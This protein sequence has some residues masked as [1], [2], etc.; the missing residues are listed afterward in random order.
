MSQES[1]EALA[2]RIR[3]RLLHAEN[4]AADH[5]VSIVG[6]GV[7]A[8]TL[9]LEIRRARPT[10]RILI[11]EPN[12]HPVPEVTHTVGE[13]TVEVSAHY[14]RDRLG[15]GDHLQSSQL[16]KMGLRMFFSH[17]GNTDIAQRMEL[18]S[19]SFVPQVTYQIDRGRL[20][21]ELTRRCRSE[22]VDIAAAECVRWSS[23]PATVRTRSPFKTATSSRRPRRVGWLTRL[24]ATGCCLGS[25]I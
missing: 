25:W 5:D 22:D 8:L 15:L 2:Q 18:G 1:R 19:S 12:D 9:A 14:L 24:A 6:G 17:D 13:S 7:A 3:S 4:P 23:A 16:R 20:E 21:N 11:V 10:T